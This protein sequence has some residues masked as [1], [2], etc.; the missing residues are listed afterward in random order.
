MYFINNEIVCRWLF[1]YCSINSPV[2]CQ[3]IQKDLDAFTK[4]E[5]DWQMSFNVDKCH[6][7]YF[8]TKKSNLDTTYV[9]NNHVLTK[10]HHHSY[11]GVI[12]SEDLK[13]S[14]HIVY[15]TS[16]TKQT[17]GITGRNFR[18]VSVDCKSKL[19]HSLVR[20]K[21]E[22]ANSAWY[23]Y[24]QKDIHHPDMI[25]RSAARLCFKNY[26]KEPGEVTDMLN[27]LEWPSF[28]GRRILYWLSMF[29][30]IVY[31]TVDINKDMYLTPFPRTSRSG[32]SKTFIRPHSNCNQYAFSFFPWSVNQWNRHPGNIL[33]I[34]DN[35][36]FKAA[37]SNHLIKTGKWF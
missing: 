10:V 36:K 11:L 1:L 3:N 7:S 20:P 23:P 27:K 26:S 37:L 35:L 4:W 34:D 13:W 30:W 31:P 32:N 28:E 17:L 9:L 6:T 2:D 18:N 21:I 19:Y 14:E 25:Q 33:N 16:S 29:H 5:K 12:L 8:S 22:Y 15:M 24:L